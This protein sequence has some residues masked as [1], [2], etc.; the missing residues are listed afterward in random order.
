VS[1]TVLYYED[2]TGRE[3]VPEEIGA[4]P[5][6]AR[7]KI[8]RF[9]DLMEEEGPARL[10]SDYTRHI[11]GDIWEL[12]IDSGSDRFRVLYFAVV[13]RTVIL[14]RAFL[15]KTRRT[16]PAEIAA[17]SSRRDDALRRRL[18]LSGEK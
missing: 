9:I 13:D 17:A 7:A 3:S 8:L 6:K 16:P 5:K 11:A 2:E 15:K 4:F 18:W 10:G 1:W 14:L 12:R